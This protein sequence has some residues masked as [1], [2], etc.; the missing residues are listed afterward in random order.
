MIGASSSL[1]SSSRSAKRLGLRWAWQIP[2]YLASGH[3]VSE[4]PVGDSSL[5]LPLA[6]VGELVAIFR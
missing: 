6:R 1:I 4:K 3:G 2:A 5:D